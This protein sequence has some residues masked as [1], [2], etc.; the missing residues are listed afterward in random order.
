M[1]RRRAGFPRILLGGGGN[2]ASHTNYTIDLEEGDAHMRRDE[3]V[4][5]HQ[6]HIP[7]VDFRM[8]VPL[9][10]VT[11][12]SLL[13]TYLVMKVIGKVFGL[14]MTKIGELAGNLM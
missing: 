13:V 1:P 4:I 10:V 3:V 12:V 9:C 11:T 8:L 5:I 6:I 14:V 2:A 7:E